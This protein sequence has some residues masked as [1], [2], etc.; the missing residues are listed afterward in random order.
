MPIEKLEKDIFA[1]TTKRDGNLAVFG[2]VS[3]DCIMFFRLSALRFRRRGKTE[4]CITLK[5]TSILLP[6]QKQN[7]ILG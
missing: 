2:G 6:I 3:H 1:N 4:F 7:S 5:Q